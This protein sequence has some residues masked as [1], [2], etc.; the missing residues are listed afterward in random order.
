MALSGRE[1]HGEC[2]R[3]FLFLLFSA[4]LSGATHDGSS[5]DRRVLLTASCISK[6]CGHHEAG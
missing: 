3:S 2:S 5:F 6:K 4:K 1:E